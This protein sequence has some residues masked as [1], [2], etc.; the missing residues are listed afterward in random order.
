M[1][2]NYRLMFFIFIAL[3]QIMLNAQ[4]PVTVILSTTSDP[5]SYDTSL[6]FNGG[7]FDQ[8]ASPVVTDLDGDG[9]KDFIIG[10]FEGNLRHYEQDSVN[11]NSYT[12]ITDTF[13]NIDVGN[14]SSPTFTD[15]DGDGKLD[16]LVGEL[17][18]NI[19]RYEQDAVN[20][21]SFSL[22]T[23]NFN[24]IDIGERSSPEVTD[25]DGDG[26]ID[27]M[28]GKGDGTVARW[29]QDSANSLSFSN[30]TGSF[31]GIN[32]INYATPAFTDLD[33]DGLIDML[34][35]GR[36]NYFATIDCYG[37][38][39]HYEQ[40]SQNSSTFNLVTSNYWRSIEEY[41]EP[42]LTD[43]DGDYLLN[44]LI[45]AHDTI[46]R[47][48]EKEAA[49]G[50]TYYD[51]YI[52]SY[53]WEASYYLRSQN[54]TGNLQISVGSGFKI[55]LNKD[56][57]YT[58]SISI[59]NSGTFF[60]DFYLR[61]TPEENIFYEDVPI[62]ISS[63]DMET[64][65]IYMSGNCV[66]Y[67]KASQYKLPA[68]LSELTENFVSTGS[69]K[70]V[71]LITDI[72]KDGK[73][74]I[75]IGNGNGYLKLYEQNNYKSTNMTLIE[76][77]LLGTDIGDN[78]IPAICDLDGDGL[79]D[80]L[81][82][83]ADGN[84]NHYEQTSLT[85]NEFILV[86]ADFNAIDVGN[87]SAPCIDY[88]DNDGLLD[89]LIGKANGTILYYEQ[90]SVNST[91]F[92]LVT[93]DF[94]SID[95]GD[96][97]IP[98]L[99]DYDKDGLLDLLIGKTG[100]Y[101][102]HYEQNSP[103]SLTFDFLEDRFISDDLGDEVAPCITDIDGDG[104]I[105]LLAGNLDGNLFRF[106]M[107]EVDTLKFGE[108]SVG[109]IS[110]AD[111][112][113]VNSQGLYGDLAINA[114]VG[115]QVSLSENSGYQSSISIPV[116]NMVAS[117]TVFVRF[118][119][120]Y[121]Q[122][123]FSE[124]EISSENTTSVY[125]TLYGEGI[126]SSVCWVTGSP[127]E[128][129]QITTN[130]NSIVTGSLSKP[131]ITDF[132]GDGM[133]D[134]LIGKPTGSIA[135][136]RQMSLNSATFGWI[137]ES[138]S[139]IDI[140]ENS[141]PAF[142]DIDGNGLIDLF[143]GKA[144][145]SIARYEQTYSGSDTFTEISINFNNIDVGDNS[146]PFFYDIDGDGLLDLLIG[147][148]DGQIQ[149]YE[150]D[151]QYSSVFILANANFQSI[152][153]GNE[154]V[155]V[156]TDID[157]D[158]YLDLLI[159][160]S[161]GYIARYEQTNVNSYAFSL[162]TDQLITDDL[163]ANVAPCI[164]DID[165]DNYFD[166]LIGENDGNVDHY[167]QER[168]NSLVFDSISVG[169]ISA[170]QEYRIN[171]TGI[172][173]DL[174]INAPLGFKIKRSGDPDYGSSI[175]IPDY[176][177]E[178]SEILYV[179]FEPT[180]NMSYS[181]QITHSSVDMYTSFLSVS[182]TVLNEPLVTVAKL[183]IEPTQLS[184]YFNSINAGSNSAP[185]IIDIDRDGLK[186]LVIGNADGYLLHFEQDSVN[187]GTFVRNY[188]S[189]DSTQTSTYTKPCFTD[190]DGDNLTDMLVGKSGGWIARYEQNSY[191]SD[192]FVEIS[193][194]LSGLDPGNNVSPTV[195][196]IDANG[197]LDLLVGKANGQIMH[198]E[199]AG[200]NSSTFILISNEFNSIDIGDYSVPTLT[201]IDC[202]GLFDLVIGKEEGYI[203]HYEQ[204]EA[205]S[206]IFDHVADRLITENLG[207]GAAPVCDDID[208]DGLLDIIIGNNSGILYRYEISSVD[209]L[210][211][212]DTA[213]G[214]SSSSQKYLVNAACLNS[215][216]TVTSP[217]GFNISLTESG[218]Y[219]NSLNLTKSDTV[220]VRFEPSQG[221]YYTDNLI[222]S[223]SEV[224]DIILVVTGTGI[225]G[226]PQNITTEISGTD[227]ILTWDP[228]SG[229]ASY[230]VYSSDDPYGTFTEEAT[231][232]V[233]ETW[234]TEYSESKK[235]Y[236]IVALDGTKNVPKKVN[237]K[238]IR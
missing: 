72:N 116:V 119:P 200:I 196:D 29:E 163:G 216:L 139:G 27:L 225:L 157:R 158:N 207:S 205:N 188:S 176:A 133:L 222:N 22:Q 20:S 113:F 192:E 189:L 137:S 8:Y 13:N 46:F 202:D 59:A 102:A 179:R 92:T 195:A 146:A 209:S 143:I 199:Q 5:F 70:T 227:L 49:Y 166:L 114:P 103:N 52:G 129:N 162:V 111:K 50:F 28:I 42:Y 71:P 87:N 16:L 168:L 191:Y 48:E 56:F 1:F 76:S 126:A 118:E 175:I 77:N 74:E 141:A 69:V 140:G 109:D 235:F 19:N 90:N 66:S 53:S 99:T 88:I 60:G 174:Y 181:G 6:N 127:V 17:D 233:G 167:E 78:A 154:S 201:D 147:S 153:I 203:A 12:K 182:G 4:D 178:F 65:Y 180:V 82:G 229:A 197:L 84:I 120:V 234:T 211:F 75:V 142:S 101:I 213:I 124:I 138:F 223:T 24:S 100:G 135:Y 206:L 148:S 7:G 125:V 152:D 171:V 131:A 32:V 107:L 108:V 173:D 9:L 18:G 224:S 134:L 165:N 47:M 112:F 83:E 232:P 212:E 159:G 228:V 64:R 110:S 35:G 95:I 185:A 58:N 34:V 186:D 193:Q 54:L 97:A 219:T 144:D 208:N 136:Y 93:T 41:P 45:G 145:G 117:D 57:G 91:S 25:I 80:L 106:E 36:D 79:F 94:N 33:D 86:T 15:L 85:T 155:P 130:F 31:N 68:E 38:I 190:I 204:Q 55:S 161:G 81:I 21:L 3:N 218:T 40:D 210:D 105:D 221:I 187:S 150:Q 23:S 198:Y 104:A 121:G 230:K 30:V 220:F 62:V 44:L 73:K 215:Y 226:I 26:L 149:R 123:Y 2:K 238:R 231:A 164:T 177:E 14:F 39:S 151:M 96:N 98:V 172:T 10:G 170:P 194:H 217:E 63:Q 37:H 169:S 11:S 214:G 67:P 115:F 237:I 43:L 89:L 51:T 183:P 156:I 128:F 132:N 122:E 236:Y 61:F 184:S 160:K